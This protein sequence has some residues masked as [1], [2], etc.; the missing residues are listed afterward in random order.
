MLEKG[1]WNLKCKRIAVSLTMWDELCKPSYFSMSTVFLDYI[2]SWKE[3]N[4]ALQTENAK[5]KSWKSWFSVWSV[6][7]CVLDSE[8]TGQEHMAYV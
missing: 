7:R 3:L 2:S 5:F 8:V 1:L 4:T 6:N